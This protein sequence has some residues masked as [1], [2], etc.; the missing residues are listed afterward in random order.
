M[1]RNISAISTMGFQQSII[2]E[3]KVLLLQ[4]YVYQA[5]KQSINAHLALL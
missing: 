3:M 2:H 4:A 5:I 1:K